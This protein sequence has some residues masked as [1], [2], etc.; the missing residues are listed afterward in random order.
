[1]SIYQFDPNRLSDSHFQ[2]AHLRLLVSGNCGRL[3][4]KRRTPV[5]IEQVDWNCGLFRLLV[6]AFEDKGK[7]WDLPF[8]DVLRFQFALDAQ[9]LSDQELHKAESLVAKFSRPL[10]LQAETSARIES[11]K[12]IDQNS[13]AIVDWLKKNSSFDFDKGS[14]PL[15][16]PQQNAEILTGLNRYMSEQGLLECEKRTSEIYVLNPFS[17]EWIKGLQ[18][19]L[20][21]MGIKDFCGTVPR[22]ADIFSGLGAKS[23]RRKYLIHRLAYV[24]A[25]YGLLGHSSVTLYRGMSCEGDWK[26]NA[27][28]FFSS[29]S[30]SKSIAEAFIDMA[31]EGP[32]RHSYLLKRSFSV[33]KLFMTHLETQA[34][35][36][37]YKEVEAVIIHDEDDRLLW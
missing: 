28:K 15:S 10:K 21:E 7:H 34:M 16:E 9:K 2:A 29:W 35:N 37:Q 19:V 1:M 25:I 31:P 27:P 24:R 30:F 17:G 3:L 23:E 13:C 11:E 33:S 5:V 32:A 22:T 4:D 20:A 14:P 26:V 8:E 6:S 36:N 18:I 12:Q